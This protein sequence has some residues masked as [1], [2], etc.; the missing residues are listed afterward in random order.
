L[1]C[2]GI[3]GKQVPEDTCPCCGQKLPEKEIVK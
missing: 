3:F 1:L 2:I